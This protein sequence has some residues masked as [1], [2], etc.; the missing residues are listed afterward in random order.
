M[1]ADWFGAIN[2]A[3]RER[4]WYEGLVIPRHDLWSRT[5]C[6][7]VTASFSQFRTVALSMLPRLTDAHDARKIDT[8]IV[9]KFILMFYIII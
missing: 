2:L 6:S 4:G 3:I 5:N 9:E 8:K 1:T 7:V